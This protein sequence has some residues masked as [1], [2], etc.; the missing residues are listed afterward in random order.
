[1][2]LSTSVVTFNDHDESTAWNA[3]LFFVSKLTDSTVMEFINNIFR[4]LAELIDDK[5]C[6]GVGRDCCLDL[7]VKF[8]DRANGCNWTN[9]FILTGKAFSVRCPSA[10]ITS[11]FLAG[12]PKVLRVAATVPELSD[13][14]KKQ[15]L[16]TAQ[17]KMHLS[18]VLSIIYHDLCSDKEREEFNNECIEFI[19]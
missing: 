15:Y 3:R 18:C 17:T 9:K 16:V 14:D 1:M 7:V 8:V 19:K 5:T 10:A 13:N 6:S 11:I 12:L 2:C 4:M